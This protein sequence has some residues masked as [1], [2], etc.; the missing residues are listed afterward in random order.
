MKNYEKIGASGNAYEDACKYL[1]HNPKTL[2]IVTGLPADMAKDLVARFKIMMIHAA[3]NKILKFKPDPANAAQKK[4]WLWY[5]VKK[6]KKSKESPAG[7]GFVDVLTDYGNS[8][9]IVGPRLS[10]ESPEVAYYIDKIARPYYLDM[11]T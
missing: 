4:Y 9:T 8:C 10:T 3:I 2:P 5:W 1:K 6:V 11:L 7:F